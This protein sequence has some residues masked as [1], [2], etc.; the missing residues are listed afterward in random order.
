MGGGV[1]HGRGRAI[2]DRR[3]DAGRDGYRKQHQRSVS[4]ALVTAA[5]PYPNRVSDAAG[6]LVLT[7]SA[8]ACRP[9]GEVVPTQPASSCRRA[10]VIA[11]QRT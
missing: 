3:G 5:R 11:P 10:G 4:A 6:D 7:H 1:L 8:S 9:A 2:G